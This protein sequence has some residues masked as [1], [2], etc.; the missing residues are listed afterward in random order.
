MQMRTAERDNISGWYAWDCESPDK[1]SLLMVMPA[2]ADKKDVQY[3]AFERLEFDLEQ[4]KPGEV[5][6]ARKGWEF[7]SDMVTTWNPDGSKRETRDA[8]EVEM[9]LVAEVTAC[10]KVLPRL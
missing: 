4:C 3:A 2:C 1:D 5:I 8:T 6:A 10:R 7:R 9:D